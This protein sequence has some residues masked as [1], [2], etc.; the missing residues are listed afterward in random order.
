MSAKRARTLST[1]SSRQATCR[2]CEKDL[3]GV[4]YKCLTCVD[5]YLCSTCF[6]IDNHNP[7]HFLLSIGDPF[8]ATYGYRCIKC[9]G[10]EPDVECQNC[11][12]NCEGCYCMTC[13]RKLKKCVVCGRQVV[14]R[15]MVVE[16]LEN[17]ITQ[18]EAKANE[19][20]T[21][22]SL[23]ARWQIDAILVQLETLQDDLKRV[24]SMSDLQFLRE[25]Y[26]F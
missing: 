25:R 22:S 19:Y 9:P 11:G 14:N 4:R 23:S 7:R 10:Q 2:N 5:Y 1:E 12:D 18:A 26:Q 13:S 17:A 16:E 3:E 24:K 15:G 6:E 20:A 21:S 8:Y